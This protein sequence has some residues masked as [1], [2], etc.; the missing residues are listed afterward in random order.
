MGAWGFIEEFIE[1]VARELGFERPQLRYAGR[2]AAASPATGLASRHKA[3]Q[4]TLIEDALTVGKERLSRI[5]TRKAQQARAG[6]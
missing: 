6:V 1:E 4:E 3:Q 2:A 5:G